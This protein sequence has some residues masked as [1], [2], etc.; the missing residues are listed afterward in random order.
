MLR[1]TT[2]IDEAATEL[3]VE[4]QISGDDVEVLRSACLKAQA[5]SNRIFLDFTAV[6]C[7]DRRGVGVVRQLEELGAELRGTSAVVKALLCTE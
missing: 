4:G 2:V 3:R 6:S 1:I 5:H 7:I